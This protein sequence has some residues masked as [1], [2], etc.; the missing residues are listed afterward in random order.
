MKLFAFLSLSTAR[1]RYATA[2]AVAVAAALPSAPAL[3]SD[4][5]NKPVRIIVPFPP[6]GGTDAMARMFADKLGKAMGQP[7]VIDN[8]A[9]AT[10]TI[11]TNAVAAAVP[12]G[13]TLL[14]GSFSSHVLAPL[15]L[16]GDAKVADPVKD[17]APIGMLA[18]HPMVLN[19]HPSVKASTVSELVAETK[20]RPMFYASIG[21]GSLF[22]FAGAEF[23][24]LTGAAATHV[25]Y[26]GA[27]PALADLL[28]GQV[29]MMFDTIQSSLPHI[30]KGSLKPI[31]VTGT[32]RSPLLPDVPTL[33]EAG[34]TG[35]DVTSWVG[36]LA[37]AGTPPEIVSKL[38]GQLDKL[39]QDREFV[40]Q[41]AKT[42]TDIPRTTPDEF[43]EILIK[44]QRKYKAQFHKINL[45]K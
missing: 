36:M 14:V 32:S 45:A 34:L 2:C 9:G 10:G 15:T 40:A 18:Y 20:A 7:F 39:A 21:N 24:Q 33:A 13:Y 27:A 41:A 25:P 4:Y 23:N 17:F 8:R 22:H 37:P 19:V 16:E 35:F 26:R 29:H 5:P 3:A 6:G 28:G 43:R 38:A 12:D 30:R 44:D 1:W 11:G 42:G 31:A